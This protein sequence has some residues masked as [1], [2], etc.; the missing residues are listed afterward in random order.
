[1]VNILICEDEKIQ[2][3]NM[4]KK[5]YSKIDS[6]KLSMDIVISS[7]NVKKVVDYS[8]ESRNNNNLYFFDVELTDDINGIEKAGEIRKNDPQAMIVFVTSHSEM[9]LLTFEYKVQASDYI[10]KNSKEFDKRIE[11]CLISADNRFNKISEDESEYM[12]IEN[13]EKVLKQKIDDILFIETASNH[14][15]RIHIFDGIIETYGSIKEYEE[16]LPEYFIKTHRSFLVNSRNIKGV[17]KALR[18][19]EMKNGEKCLMSRLCI[20]DVLKCVK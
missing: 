1:M 13:S 16:R 10:V 4:E 3:D 14:R 15:I 7:E 9:S 20:K 12:M 8:I 2:R 17:D 19:I 6:L 11:E 5:I 18:T